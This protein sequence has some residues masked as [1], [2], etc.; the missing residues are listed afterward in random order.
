MKRCRYSP[1]EARRL[2]GVGEGRRGSLTPASPPGGGCNGGI[3]ESSHRSIRR[4]SHERQNRSW[5]CSCRAMRCIRRW[6]LRSAT[7]LTVRGP[8]QVGKLF[9]MV[10]GHVIAPARMQ[11]RQALV[12]SESVLSRGTGR[13]RSA[14]EP[15]RKRA[16]GN[17]R[18]PPAPTEDDRGQPLGAKMVRAACVRLPD[19]AVCRPY[20]FSIPRIRLSILVLLLEPG[21]PAPS[22]PR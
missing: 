10:S 16:Y 5:R 6:Y 7:L 9:L 18:A 21:A 3:L 22:K 1:S 8:R 11:S 19:L 13:S 12:P 17:R 15:P 2:G 4:P 20:S 14:S